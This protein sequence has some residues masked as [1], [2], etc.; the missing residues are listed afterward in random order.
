MSVIDATTVLVL[1]HAQG[2]A[3]LSP[4]EAD[5][6]AAGAT[7]AIVAVRAALAGHGLQLFDSDPADFQAV[8]ESLSEPRP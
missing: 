4:D 6:I 3:W 8:L 2:H 1:A 7:D 5:R